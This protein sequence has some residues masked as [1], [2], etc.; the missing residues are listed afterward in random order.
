MWGGSADD[1]LTRRELVRRGSAG[2]AALALPALLAACGSDSGGS[3]SA[4]SGSPATKDEPVKGGKLRVGF[5]GGGSAEQLDP[6]RGAVIVEIAMATMM[7]DKLFEL[8]GEKAEITPVLAESMEPNAK[9]DVW[10]LRV[11][12][13]VTWHDGKP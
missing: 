2:G 3:Q 12:D 6:N 1:G 7:F 5:V 9:G 8:R 11:K 10:T 13:G 4:S